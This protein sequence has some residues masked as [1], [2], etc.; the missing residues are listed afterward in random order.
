[1]IKVLIKGPALSRSGYGEHTRYMFRALSTRPDLFDL[2]VE[3]T[4]WGQSSWNLD[5][6]Q[7]TKQ[8]ESCIEK[9]AH[10]QGRFDVSLQVLIPNE[11]QNLAEKNIGVTAG[12][13]TDLASAQWVHGCRNM[14]RVVV[15]S[16]RSSRSDPVNK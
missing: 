4:N 15:V 5:S 2:Y 9:L 13:E 1:M 6:S 3:P 12:I 16:N 10:F 8:I 7:E 14:D 11:W